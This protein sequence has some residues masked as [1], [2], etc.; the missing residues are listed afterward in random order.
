MT[1]QKTY[2]TSELMFS[3]VDN[4]EKQITNINAII[5]V[6]KE[7]AFDMKTREEESVCG[8]TREQFNEIAKLIH[9]NDKMRNALNNIAHGE[10]TVK[11]YGTVYMGREEEVTLQQYAEDAMKED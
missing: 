9:M 7:T 4:L 2:T 8:V 6:L 11:P 10:M 3:V 1:E 5:G